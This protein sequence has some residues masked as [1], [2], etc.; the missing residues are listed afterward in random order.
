MTNFKTEIKTLLNDIEDIRISCLDTRLVIFSIRWKLEKL[1]EKC[2]PK[3]IIDPPMTPQ[4]QYKL[5][6]KERARINRIG[7]LEKK[8]AE[9]AERYKGWGIM[10]W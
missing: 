2:E 3:K 7:R 8:K 4:E 5:L 9:E 6:C 10:Y 1:I